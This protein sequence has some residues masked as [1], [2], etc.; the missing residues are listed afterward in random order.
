ML[1]IILRLFLLFALLAGSVLAHATH[2]VGGEIYYRHLGSN[3]YEITLKIYRDCSP[4]N[5]NNTYFDDFA[6]VGIYTGGGSYVMNYLMDLAGADISTVP[7][8]IDNPCFSAP[9][10]VCVQE[11]IYIGT[12]NLPPHPDGYSLIYQ[13]CC[14]NP[15]IMNINWPEDAGA[16]FWTQIPPS[17]VVT[18]NSNPVFNNLPPVAL[19]AGAQFV[20]DHSATD[21]DGDSLVYTFCTPL[22]GGVPDAPAPSPPAPPPFN[23]VSWAAGFNANNPITADPIFSIDPVT[24]EITGTPTAPGQF[25]LGVCVEEYRDGVLLSTTNRDFQF[26]V[27]FC[28]PTFIVTIPEQEQFCDGLTFNFD[29][30]D[31]NADQFYWDFGD[32]NSDEDFSTEISPTWTYSDTGMYVVTLIA[33]P[34]WNCAD[35]VSTTYAAYPE[36]IPVILEDSYN[37]DT[38][39]GLYSFVAGG[40]YGEEASFLWDFGPS[41]SPSTSTDQNPED[42]TFN[43]AEFDISLTV[44]ENG[45]ETVVEENFVPPPPPV[46][47]IAPQ[48]TFCTGLT[49]S[50]ENDSENATS[51]VWDFGLLG[52]DDI[53]TSIS[54]QFTYPD[55]GVYTITLLASAFGACPDTAQIDIEVYWLLDAF[56]VPPPAQCFTGNA[57]S[58]EGEGTVESTAVYE[59]SFEGSASIPSHNGFA[60]P[61]IS[62]EE[63]G[64]F[65]VELSVSANGCVDT[66]SHPIEVIPD[67]SID[68]SG[69]GERCPP[70]PVAFDNN[71]FTFTSASYLWNFGDGSTSTQPNPTHTYA[72]PGTY[73]VTLFMTTTGDCSQD[74]VMV[75]PDA[76]TVFPVPSAGFDVEPN[77]VDI[78]EPHVS[79]TDL[80]FGGTSVI[81]NFGDGGISQEWNP[82]YSY[83]GSGIFQ[84]T[85]TV[86]N[87]FGCR[88]RATG[89][90]S[91]EGT[92]FYAPNAFTPDNDGI[93]DYWIPVVTGYSR[94][95]LEVYNRWGEVIFETRDPN[96]VWSGNVKGGDHY[97]QNGLYVYR[98]V[99]HD[100]IGLPHEFEG[101]IS[102]IR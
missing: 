89:E 48:E 67:P 53:S 27:T 61:P 2:I 29:V 47:S 87:E 32:P 79:V 41:A 83:T 84:L 30:G 68:F 51:Y 69:G 19:C 76:V 20:F 102:L 23:P 80:S 28:E 94:F 57:F 78:L 33:N 60:P 31:T 22:L 82:E 14:R 64:V 96:I 99:V 39:V 38:G 7:V 70:F 71:S 56:F 98:C 46:A 40:E 95:H 97:A 12:V 92:L 50:F 8:V 52:N 49:Y 13:R 4:V 73:D 88:A 5:S 6:S 72:Q 3:D 42:I 65:E 93:N 37:C 75:V 101:H 34:G 85:Q 24:G 11:A 35:T 59:W 90:V 100:L 86:E 44:F 43:S 15:S 62:W 63:P 1:Q 55:T 77:T 91:V 21:L 45:C 17:N 16:T 18:V 54:P 81:Y 58:F 26:N 74:L 25:V 66:F 9:P 36:I 10:N